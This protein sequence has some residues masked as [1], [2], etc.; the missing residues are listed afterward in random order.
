MRQ[1]REVQLALVPAWGPHQHTREL[2]IAARILDEHPELGELVQADL[3]A[4]QRSDTGRPGLRGAQVLRIALLKQTHG[5]S[6]RELEFH[7]QDS[8]AF[9][10]FVGLGFTGFPVFQTLQ[11]NVKRIRAETWEAIHRVLVRFARAQGI[12]RGDRIRSDTTAVDANIHEPSD[13]SLL[14]DCVRV[15]TRLLKRMARHH[16]ALRQHFRDHTRRAKRRAYEIKFSARRKDRPQGYRD[17]VRVAEAVRNQ[18][19]DVLDRVADR[20]S[21]TLEELALALREVLG[22]LDR[23]LDQAKRRVFEGERVPAAEKLVSIFEPHADILVKG[24]RDVQYGHKIC[25]TGGR[26]SLILDCVIEQGNPPDAT[27]VE[28]TLVRHRDLFGRAP[29]QA[30]FDGGFASRAN[31]ERA[32]ELGVE[33]IAFHRK[34]GLGIHE[35]ARSAWIFRRLRNWRSGIEGCISTVKRAFQLG[36]CTWRGL[37]SFQAYVWASVTSYN[38]VVLARH[39]LVREFA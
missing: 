15:A 21:R 32:K 33:D 36:R 1:F 29:R 9:R 10:A 39:L 13:S 26:S 23:I 34:A 7:L 38:L 8:A 5:L 18:A 35:M 6:Y 37:G 14:W 20:S 3:V 16:P 24:Q 4:G 31:L 17:L 12:E 11:M 28:R 25:L 22:H 30:C 27:L 19:Q 2:Q